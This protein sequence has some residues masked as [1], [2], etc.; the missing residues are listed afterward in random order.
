[1][2]RKVST[3]GS[4][5]ELREFYAELGRRH[6]AALWTVTADLLPREPKTKVLPW[7][8]RWKE[9]SA[10]ALR[11]GE[12]VPIERG[13]E[14]RVLALVNP[15]L[16]GK[17]AT[18]HTLWGAVQILLPRETAPAHRHTPAAIRFILEGEG[19]FTTVE[20]DKCVMGPGDLVLTPPWTWHDHG[21][22]GDEPVIWFDGLDLPLVH[23][24]DAVFFEPYPD[25]VQPVT[26]VNEAERRFRTGQLMPTWARP[27]GRS[28][29]LYNYKWQDARAGL[30]RLAGGETSP[31]DDVALEYTNPATGGPVLPTLAC[32][33]QLLRP[34]VRTR[35]HRHASSA[36]Y[37]AFS[38]SGE[39]IISGMRFPWER[40]DM[41]VIPPWAWHEHVNPTSAEAILFS[42]HDTPVM[43]ALGLYRE[44][45]YPAG[46]QGVT[47]V[48]DT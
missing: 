26:A 15:G 12:L 17:Y 45:P 46:H 47:G 39:S 44:E 31:Y 24:L 25:H 19:A 5:E 37:V 13:G 4:A 35:A 3:E 7:L 23:D 21:N 43:D 28:S 36:V 18:T 6:L 11:A 41:F 40:G 34:G 22:E 2:D 48:F 27:T 29:P 33:I 16:G 1:M 42:I 30:D 20:G 8:W 9:M 10:L 38:G 14:R 32:W